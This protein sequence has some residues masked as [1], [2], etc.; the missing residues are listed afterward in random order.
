[1]SRKRPPQHDPLAV[2]REFFS[3]AKE[4]WLR[5]T[6][7]GTYKRTRATALLNVLTSLARPTSR[8]ETISDGYLKARK[9]H[10]K[11]P[12][13]IVKTLE[14]RYPKFFLNFPTRTGL[15]STTKKAFVG[16]FCKVYL[17]HGQ[18]QYGKVG[19]RKATEKIGPISDVEVCL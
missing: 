3:E 17:N 9:L 19:L 4:Q 1:M 15:T 7:P 12:A 13:L 8:A 14:E 5:F 11:E 2:D 16:E 18:R 6:V 10:D